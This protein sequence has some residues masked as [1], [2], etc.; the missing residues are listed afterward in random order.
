ME[1]KLFLY[2]YLIFETSIYTY[3]F[4][5]TRQEKEKM[6]EETSKTHVLS[7]VNE[8]LNGHV[9]WRKATL[10]VYSHLF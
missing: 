2:Y 4:H 1:K 5:D 7:I 3:T 10:V 9:Q 6:L 8:N